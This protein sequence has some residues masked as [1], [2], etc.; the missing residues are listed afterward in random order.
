MQNHRDEKINSRRRE[1]A[2]ERKQVGRRQ[3]A[4]FIFPGRAMLEQRRDGDDEEAAEESEQRQ[5]HRHMAERKTVP[6]QQ[7]GHDRHA[8]RT[9]RDE[10]VFNFAAGKMTRRVTAQAD[11]DGCRRL[12]IAGFLRVIY[13][14]HVLGVDHDEQLNQRGDGEEVGVAERGQRKHPVLTDQLHLPPK[15]AQKI[16]AEFF[17]WIGGG[18][19]RDAEAD[20]ESDHGQ[21]QQQHA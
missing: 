13:A 1:D 17:R 4:A 20:E 11:A 19:L 14:Q 7:R 9:E 18:N 12:E 16:G 21:R 8:H 10:A 2:N 3:Y 15:V 5:I 6:P